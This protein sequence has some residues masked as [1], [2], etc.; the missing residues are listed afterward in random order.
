MTNYNQ[1]SVEQRDIIQTLINLKKSFTYISSVIDKDRTTISKE[2]KR[3]RYIK[4]NFY[5]PFDQKGIKNAVEKCSIL[6]KPPYVLSIKKELKMLL[7][8]A[9]FYLNHHMCVILVQ[10]KQLV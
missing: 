5:E 4:S 9:V 7:K 10:K 6:S 8:N 2:I 3:N 1:L